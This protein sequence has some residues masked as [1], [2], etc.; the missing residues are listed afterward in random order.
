VYDNL[1]VNLRGS[2]G[3]RWLLRSIE[4]LTPNDWTSDG[5]FIL[6][7]RSGRKTG[8]DLLVFPIYAQ[9]S[10]AASNT[11][12]GRG[13]QAQVESIVVADTEALES[14][15]RFSP[16][17]EWIAYQSNELGDRNEIYV[18]P[19]PGTI[20]MRKKVSINGGSSPKWSRDGRE[21]YFMSSDNR[22]MVVA[23]KSSAGKNIELDPPTPLFAKVFPEGTEF[24]PHPDGQRFLINAS[25][26]PVPPIYVMSDWLSKVAASTGP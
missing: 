21:L 6:Y 7:R 19:F 12:G 22:V 18:Q 17:G 14:D 9:D 23:V 15:G 1:I 26:G 13:G 16:N 20:S 11:R 4:N 2:N 3:V 25:T 8:K 5:R 10:L 24:E